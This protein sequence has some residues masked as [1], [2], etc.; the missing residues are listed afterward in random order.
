M[1]I[2]F[3]LT[4]VLLAFIY[5]GKYVTD[6]PHMNIENMKWNDLGKKLVR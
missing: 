5:T 6:E 1:G 2:F 4:C 3:F